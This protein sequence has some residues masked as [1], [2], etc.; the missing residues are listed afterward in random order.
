MIDNRGRFS[1]RRRIPDVDDVGTRTGTTFISDRVVY[2]TS[3]V[4]HKTAIVVA[5]RRQPG[6]GE[7]H[8]SQPEN[9]PSAPRLLRRSTGHHPVVLNRSTRV[10]I[11][12]SATTPTSGRPRMGDAGRTE[13][14]RAG[15]G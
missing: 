6:N 4:W 13:V 7:L 1:D 12:A 11:G 5:H 9:P 10:S 14:P 2:V 3:R 8:A 15:V